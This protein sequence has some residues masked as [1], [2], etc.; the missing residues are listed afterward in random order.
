MTTYRSSLEAIGLSA[1]RAMH[2]ASVVPQDVSPQGN[3]DPRGEKLPATERPV[4]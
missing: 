2:A 3:Q 1:E 4:T